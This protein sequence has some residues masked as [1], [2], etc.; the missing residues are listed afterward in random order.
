[1]NDRFQLTVDDINTL[2]RALDIV[3]STV[4]NPRLRPD[5]VRDPE[6]IPTAYLAKTPAGGIAA[7]S[8]TTPGSAQCELYAVDHFAGAVSDIG[9]GIRIYNALATSIPGTAFVPV[10]QEKSGAFLATSSQTAAGGSLT[11]EKSDLSLVINPCT[12]IAIEVV[13]PASLTP[14]GLVLTNPGGGSTA[15]I[16][17]YYATNTQQGTVSITTQMFAGLKYFVAGQV[18]VAGVADSAPPSCPSLIG[19]SSSDSGFILAKQS[20]NENPA[21]QYTVEVGLRSTFPYNGSGGSWYSMI[22][23]DGS[24]FTTQTLWELFG[25]SVSSAGGFRLISYRGQGISGLPI[26]QAP[27]YTVVDGTNTEKVGIYATV[28]LAKLTSGGAN[29]SITVSGGL[30]TAYTPPT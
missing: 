11:V 25:A 9:L 14:N 30:V 18:V 23:L 12:V 26:Q 8:G 16:Q 10:V 22:G 13:D 17:L 19:A 27:A 4:R 24:G 7:L 21:T 2:Q 28:S 15:E 1:M 3:K 29:G 5:I 6:S 20:T